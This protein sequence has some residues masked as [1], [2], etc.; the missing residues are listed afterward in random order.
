M[1]Q[2]G[3]VRSCPS[4]DVGRRHCVCSTAR[5]RLAGLA[6]TGA[7]SGG[8]APPDPCQA[9]AECCSMGLLL[10]GCVPR[11]VAVE[12]C[13]WPG[14]PRGWAQLGGRSPG[15]PLAAAVLPAGRQRKVR[16]ARSCVKARLL[17]L[18]RRSSRAALRCAALTPALSAWASRRQQEEQKLQRP[19]AQ[20]PGER[21]ASFS[22]PPLR[23]PWE[24][25]PPLRVAAAHSPQKMP[26]K[27]TAFFVWHIQHPREAIMKLIIAGSRTFTDYQLLWQTLAPERSRITQVIT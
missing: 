24:A 4:V 14:R 5:S 6:W 10:P 26:R 17:P 9:A 15:L 2:S 23:R 19:A 27:R 20:R 11:I 25:Q 7:P 18:L 21:R 8:L 13:P 22:P 3:S 1:S 12:G 16:C